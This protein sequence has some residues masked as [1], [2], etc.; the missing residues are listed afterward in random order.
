[1]RGWRGHL[2][3]ISCWGGG[4]NLFPPPAGTQGACWKLG[5][6]A[7]K[8]ERGRRADYLGRARLTNLVA[9]SF[10]ANLKVCYRAVGGQAAEAGQPVLMDSPGDGPILP[11][12]KSPPASSACV[13]GKNHFSYFALS[14]GLALQPDRPIC[15]RLTDRG[16]PWRGMMADVRGQAGVSSRDQIQGRGCTPGAPEAM[17]PRT[18]Q[19]ALHSPDFKAEQIETQENGV[20]SWGA[21]CVFPQ[22]A[23]LSSQAFPE[24][25]RGPGMLQCQ[26]SPLNRSSMESQPRSGPGKERR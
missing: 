26:Q 7:L 14:P 20:K 18:T 22:S 4:W 2:S 21:V 16:G 25:L 11:G 13:G 15:L 23:I 3:A 8:G 10:Y 19:W 12:H 5:N 9:W 1:M 24:H 17:F 6:L